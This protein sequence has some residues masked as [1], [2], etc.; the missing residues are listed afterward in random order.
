MPLCKILEVTLIYLSTDPKTFD[1]KILNGIEVI[2]SSIYT[3]VIFYL[4]YLFSTLYNYFYRMSIKVKQNTGM[5][6]SA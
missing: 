3:I 5:Q 4:I 1:N 6:K 2:S